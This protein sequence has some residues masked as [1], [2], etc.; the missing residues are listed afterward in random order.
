MGDRFFCLV[1]LSVHFTLFVLFVLCF[2]FILFIWAAFAM[3]K[4]DIPQS[5]LLFFI[6]IL[7][8]LL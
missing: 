2:Y 7:L 8:N 5:I 6:I 4:F 3:T 1:G